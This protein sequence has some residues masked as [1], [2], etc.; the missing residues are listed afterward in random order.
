MADLKKYMWEGVQ[1]GMA[2]DLYLNRWPN[3]GN[4]QVEIAES[5]HVKINGNGTILG[6]KFEFFI[7]VIM[8]DISPFGNCTVILNGSCEDGCAYNV[9]EG[10]LTINHPLTQIKI[11]DNDKKWTW[12]HIN[13]PT[14]AWIGAWPSGMKM[15]HEDKFG[16][17]V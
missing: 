6:K 1:S 5:L 7:E 16:D 12:V 4:G 14:N 9:R 15:A 11:Q 2:I 17:I 3:I 10:T 13:N 8:P